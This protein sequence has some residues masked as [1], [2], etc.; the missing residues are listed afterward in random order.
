[1]VLLMY[2]RICWVCFVFTVLLVVSACTLGP[3]YSRPDLDL[4]QNYIEGKSDSAES[5]A[6]LDWW[7][8]FQD[9]TLQDLIRTALA[10]N[11]DLQIAMSRIDEARA[12]LGFV[13]A[14]EFPR[15]DIS[16]NAERFDASDNVINF[17]TAPR[18]TF[19]IFG[20]LSF[21]IDLW[22]KLRRATEA[23][24]AELLSSEYAHRAVTITLVARV[25]T[26]YFIL[27]DLDKKK[28]ITVRT[29]DNRR[30][31][32]ELI[33][34]RFKGNVVSEL[35]VNQAEIEEAKAA[36]I[37]AN[38]ERDSRR[39]ENALSVLLGRVPFSIKRGVKLS[40]QKLPE[41]L[42]TGFQATLLERRPD[43]RSAE[44]FARA[45]VARIGVAKAEQYPSFNLLGFI[46]LESEDI[47]DLFEGSSSAKSIGGNFIGPL[48]DFGKSGSKVDVAEARA[49]QALKGYE[50]AVLQAVN[51]VE[52]ALVS[53]R[54]YRSEHDANMMQ[55][56]AAQN[57]T[58]LS[59]ARYDEGISSYLEVLDSERSLFEAEL[60][61][62]SSSQL[63]LSSIVQL[64]KALGGGWSGAPISPPA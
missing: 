7:S 38:V 53:V 2:K 4:S 19:G 15:V 1:M 60:A 24:R 58:K 47:S 43:I 29:L 51:E 41:A 20:D 57:A 49:T 40:E 22:G 55:L 63:Y 9:E 61:E 17:D 21:E 46:G 27:L 35:D 18:N 5:V 48:I 39:V 12:A 11:H 30:G 59:R 56:K 52:D 31:A 16:G 34:A 6:N 45:E 62:S 42:P 33:R 54:T 26:T 44:E 50:L 25:A 13:R 8:L 23:S 10:E 3:N 37:L 14:D 36:A 64:Y 28:A 32:T